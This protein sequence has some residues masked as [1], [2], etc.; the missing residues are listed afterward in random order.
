LLKYTKVQTPRGAKDIL[1]PDGYKRSLLEA[2]AARRLEE[3][4]YSRIYTPSLEFFDALAQGDGPQINDQ[5]YRFVDRDG[6]TLALRPEMTTP[7]A[8]VAATRFSDEDSPLRLY[9]AGSVFRYTEPQLGNSREFTQ[10]GV[11]LLGG[12]GP[13]ADAEI[14]T[15]AISLFEAL[16]LDRFQVDLGH[17]GFIEG[18]TQGIDEPGFA[19]ELK[20]ALLD[21]DYVRY[22]SIV[23]GGPVGAGAKAALLGL[24]VM[25]GGAELLAEARKVAEG[26]P[27]A[28]A[29]LDEL[30]EVYALVKAYGLAD[31][32]AI[33]LGMIKGLDYY[34]GL[35]IE[36]Y[37]PELGSSLCTGGRYDGLV[38][39]FGRDC[40]AI[41][42]AFGVER[43]MLALERQGWNPPVPV[44]SVVF[45]SEQGERE[46][47]FGAAAMARAGGISV[48]IGLECETR[49]DA[50]RYAKRRGIRR[51]ARAR[52]DGAGGLVLDAED[53][54]SGKARSASA[55]ELV[56]AGFAW[57]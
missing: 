5:L 33:D 32:V 52:R 16:G 26:A 56:R 19:A 45:W 13:S 34:T 49:E 25:R 27:A 55:D 53:L 35:L 22:E 51:I 48:E 40:P 57:A 46:A 20:K 8:R 29:A 21:R 15:L 17:I 37:A 14:V 10:I 36:G 39:K 42:F 23:S 47:L 30:S 28:L 54:E 6:T 50:A 24:P 38:G 3:W 31:R 11:E 1:P 4:G 43:V 2:T 7:V 18:L 44:P 9:Y 41:G 12:R